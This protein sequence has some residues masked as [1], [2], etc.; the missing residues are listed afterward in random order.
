MRFLSRY[1]RRFRPV[2]VLITLAIILLL[3]VAFS[4]IWRAN[5]QNNEDIPLPI[6]TPG[7]PQEQA[8]SPLPETIT[9][10]EPEQFSIIWLS[11]TQTLAYQH[12]D[13]VFQ[14]MGE[15]IIAQKESLNIRY[16]VQTGDLVDNGSTQDQ[17]ESF[18]VMLHQFYGKIPYLPIAGNHDIG[19]K[20]QDYRMYTS[21]P[22][23]KDIPQEQSFKG[24]QAV[25]ATFQAGGQDF[26]LIG[27][28]WG[29]DVSSAAWLNA[30][31]RA[32][33]DHT[34]I[35]LLHSY[36]NSRDA[37]SRQGRAM[38]E[39]VVSKNPNIR[40]VLSGHIRGSG[41]RMEEFDDDGDGEMDRQV[42]AMLYNYQEYP[43]Y[44]CGQLRIL[45]FDTQTRSI[46]VATYSPYT[47]RYYSDRHFR[48]EAFDLADVF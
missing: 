28:G 23:E 19:V 17:W 26:L 24:G 44:G 29:A 38:W 34:A 14:A 41:Y 11:D 31:L 18:N 20:S 10:A 36:V 7:L 39:L 47:D 33:P 9:A 2:R 42:H 37:L 46:H 30:V 35:L 22:F 40:L 3:I 5:D 16:I 21:L 15:W 27:A 32:H 4:G 8:Q 25:Y 43:R 45:T 1:T 13:R 12:D 48:A 6:Q